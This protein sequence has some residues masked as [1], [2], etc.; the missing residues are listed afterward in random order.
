MLYWDEPTMEYSNSAFRNVMVSFFLILPFFLLQRQLVYGIVVDLTP[1]ED[2]FY[3]IFR[4]HDLGKKLRG[5]EFRQQIY[6]VELG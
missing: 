2:Y 6:N 5:A 1:I 4:F 3:L